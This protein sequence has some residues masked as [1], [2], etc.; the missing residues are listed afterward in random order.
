M[1]LEPGRVEGMVAEATSDEAGNIPC[2]E[3]I[4]G[5]SAQAAV[6]RGFW[7]R[8]RPGLLQV[9][10]RLGIVEFVPPPQEGER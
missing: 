4:H 8:Y 5:Q 7:L 10:E 2:H 9:A 3:T 1:Q 6:C